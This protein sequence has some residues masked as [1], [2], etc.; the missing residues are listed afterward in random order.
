[1]KKPVIGILGNLLIIEGG[2]FPGIEKAYVNNDYVEAV[3]LGGGIPVLIPVSE[4]EDIIK[5]Q[6]DLVDGI[7]L[8]GGY[9]VDPL[10]YGEQPSQ[11]SGFTYPKVDEFCLKAAKYAIKKDKPVLGICKG[12][13]ILNVLYGGTLYQDLSLMD[14]CYIKHVQGSKREIPTH[15]VHIKKDSVL[16]PI[17]GDKVLTNSY[18]HQCIKSIGQGFSAAAAADDDVIEAIERTDGTFV[19]GIQWHPEMMA[20]S[21]VP[22]LNIFKKLSE[23]SLKR[24]K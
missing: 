15:L 2:M 5:M 18:H 9:D 14:G 1:M 24:S 10:I 4:D 8:S 16:F 3:T 11:K 20:K 6:I 17:L 21:S 7:I 23:E 19:L 22:M 12:I 13:Q